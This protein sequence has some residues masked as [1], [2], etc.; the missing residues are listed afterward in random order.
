MGELPGRKTLIFFSD[1][2]PREEQEMD[3]TGR[4]RTQDQ[5]MTS[6]RG[7]YLDYNS[8]LYRIAEKAIRASVVIYAIDSAGL[9]PTGLTAADRLNASSPAQA[10]NEI[11]Q[12]LRSRSR[13]IWD[14][15]EGADLI[16][17]QTGGFLVRNSNSF[18]LDRIIEEESGYYLL[19]Y[20]PAEETFNKRFHR[21]K[22]KVKRSG[23]TV[24]TRHGFYGI[25]E[26][27]AASLKKTPADQ[28]TVA[29]M[30]PFATQQIE[31]ELTAF[32][33]NEKDKGSFVRSFLYLKASDLKFEEDAEGW[34]KANVQFRGIIFGDNGV[35]VN[36]VTYDRTL[37]FRGETFQKALRSG[38]AIEFDMPVKRPGA[39][40]VRVSA[41]DI[42]LNHIGS[43]GQFVEVPN[44][45]NHRLALS[46]IV[47]QGVAGTSQDPNQETAAGPA[48]RQFARGQAIR[49]SCAIYNSM[50]DAAG[51]PNVVLQARLYR[52]AKEVYDSQ[53]MTVSLD[54]QPDFT[55]LMTAGL[56]QLD[57]KLE[58]GNYYLQLIVA[59]KLREKEVPVVQWIDFEIVK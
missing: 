49:F 5:G 59:D 33:A 19:G 16:A 39:F 44:L 46:G 14:R 58:P 13:M 8:M 17:R 31:L 18:M 12:L 24:R 22:A 36:E 6:I 9:L 3:F 51:K 37:S 11:N 40:Q 25:T 45:G 55:R 38:L 1:S 21:I 41:R 50:L 20:R 32:F 57:P 27:E 35:V 43:T 15:R 10:N 2:V 52:D 34:Q 30:S 48:V 47:L 26:D 54:M 56:V 42:L 53:P 28:A 23:T 29:L 4:D 7:D